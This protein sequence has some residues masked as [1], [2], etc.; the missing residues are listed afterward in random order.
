MTEMLTNFTSAIWSST[1]FTL[2]MLTA[3][4]LLFLKVTMI[5]TRSRDELARMEK[6]MQLLTSGS[7]GM[8]ERLLQLEASLKESGD[9]RQDDADA[10]ARSSYAQAL[11]LLQNGVDP[12]I[13]SVNCGLSDSEVKLMELLHLSRGRQAPA[14]VAETQEQE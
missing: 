10:E 8:G 12:A 13:V 2:L 9:R 5:H 4:I 3:L 14:K 7:V 11:K 6:R 1:A